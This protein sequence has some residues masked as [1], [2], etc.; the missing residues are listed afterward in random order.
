MDHGVTADFYW[1]LQQKGQATVA[2]T[3]RAES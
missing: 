1:K 2:Y 3:T